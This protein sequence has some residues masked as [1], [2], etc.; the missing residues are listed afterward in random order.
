MR[1]SGWIAASLLILSV[2]CS[3]DGETPTTPGPPVR[4]TFALAT[5]SSHTIR[6]AK[7]TFDGRDVTTVQIPGGG[8]QVSLEGLVSANKGSHTV[9]LV[10]I[11]QASSPNRY[12]G[13]GAVTAPG[14]I[15]DLV[16][17]QDVLATGQALEFRFIL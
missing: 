1:T 14:R 8:G 4:L 17:V 5:T 13:S 9:R 10:I 3:N 6:A 7:L 15:L 16:P 2:S 12:F 11:D